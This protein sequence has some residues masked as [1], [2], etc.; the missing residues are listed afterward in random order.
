MMNFIEGCKGLEFK[1]GSPEEACV[2]LLLKTAVGRARAR[3]LADVATE[4]N[5]LGYSTLKKGPITGAWVQRFVV[6]PSRKTS[7]F[8]ASGVDGIFVIESVED[9]Q[10]MLDF[11]KNRIAAENE[12]MG[13]LINL[14]NGNDTKSES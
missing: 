4:L 13:Y 14:L 2:Q 8:I 1:P 3:T 5:A 9:A 6:R 11:Y 7:A 12:N 10:V